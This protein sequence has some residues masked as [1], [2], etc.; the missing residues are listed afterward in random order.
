MK[1]ITKFIYLA[2]AKDRSYPIAMI[3]PHRLELVPLPEPSL[4]WRRRR[5]ST[6]RAAPDTSGLRSTADHDDL[7]TIPAANSR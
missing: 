5:L 1:T 2:S 3:W 4:H 7:L 6:R